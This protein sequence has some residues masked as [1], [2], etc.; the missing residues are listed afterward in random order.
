MTAIFTFLGGIGLFLFGMETMTAALRQLAGGGLRH[1][2]A[3]FTTTPLRGTLTGLAA[4]AV[5]QSSTA[6]TV[7]AIGFV[8]AGVIGF[9]QAL[10]VLFGANIGTTITGWIVVLV[11]FKMQLGLIALPVMLVASLMALLAGG[12][13]ARLGQMLAGLALLFIGLDMM[14]G[15]MSGDAAL[16]PAEFLARY[17]PGDGLIGRLVLVLVGLVLVTLTQSSTAGVALTLVLIGSGA[18]NLMQGAAM[19]IGMNIGTTFT[20]LLAAVGGSRPVRMTALANLMFNL[21]TAA[22]AFPLLSLMG[23]LAQRL[24]DD[25]TALVMFHTGFNLVGTLVFLPFT[26]GFARLIER[27]VPERRTGAEAALDAHLLDDEA[28]AMDAAQSV[29]DMVAAQQRAALR[30]ALMPPGD[31]RPLAAAEAQCGPALAAVKGYLAQIRL[32]RG[33]K[34]LMARYAAMLHQVDHLVRLQARLDDHGAIGPVGMM[35]GLL[36]PARLMLAVPADDA[37]RLDRLSRLI[38]Q[39]AK[40]ARRV[41]FGSGRAGVPDLLTR[42]DAARWLAR[43]AD[44]IA[45]ISRHRAT[46]QSGIRPSAPR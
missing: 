35:P 28:A 36:R 10:G 22:L 34:P 25:Q 3:R 24:G 1:W 23:P 42:S 13:V 32:P 8:G 38:K 20:G 41:A 46:A 44:H 4:T 19:V 18:V 14:Q 29:C 16:I 7:M 9:T 43:V 6:V 11:G 27:M 17:L 15:A 39:R 33:N 21:G 45:S 30:A 40:A 37:M 2:L 26:A 5:V 12:R 31:L